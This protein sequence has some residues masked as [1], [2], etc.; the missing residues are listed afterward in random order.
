MFDVCFFQLFPVLLPKVEYC[1]LSINRQPL[2]TCVFLN[3]YV[4]SFIPTIG[5]WLQKTCQIV[6]L[7]LNLFV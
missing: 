7:K 2:V 4:F 3:K 1:L 6:K 5:I